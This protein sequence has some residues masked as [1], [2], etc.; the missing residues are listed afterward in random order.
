VLKSVTLFDPTT[1][2]P[3]TAQTISLRYLPPLGGP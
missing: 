2:T 1:G 3:M